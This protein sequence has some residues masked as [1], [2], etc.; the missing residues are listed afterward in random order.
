MR[1]A[2]SRGLAVVF[3]TGRRYHS[4][5]RILDGLVGGEP[6]VIH[7]GAVLKDS[8]GRTAW[9]RYLDPEV[10]SLAL[11]ILTG[12]GEKPVVYMDAENNDLLL[13]PPGA[14]DDEA[15]VAY[16]S[17]RRTGCIMCSARELAS[18]PGPVTQ[19]C[20]VGTPEHLGRVA[21]RLR[22][23]LPE[24][25]CLYLH[26]PM[27]AI[28]GWLVLKDAGATKWAALAVAAAAMGVRPEEIAALG[29][30]VN[31]MEMIRNAGLGGAV[32][33]GSEQVRAVADVVVPG[34]EEEGAV[35]F[36]R[37]YVLGEV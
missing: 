31:D 20:L 30:E 37:R 15:Y 27:R 34:V 28:P 2:R 4:A 26:G 22:A 10:A 6:L 3:C 33:S 19:I 12:E 25:P 35:V 24:G 36:L 23:A 29:D 1:L 9:A 16:A 11:R 7:D 14:D 8:A 5:L 17:A 21:E 13:I 32:A 18:P